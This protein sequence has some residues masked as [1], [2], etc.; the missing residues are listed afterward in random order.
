MTIKTY[1]QEF[2]ANGGQTVCIELH[3]PPRGTINKFTLQSYGVAGNFSYRVVDRGDL[4]PGAEATSESAVPADSMDPD[5]DAAAQV[6]K[7]TVEMHEVLPYVTV[8]DGL[9]QLFQVNYQY[10]N[11]DEQRNPYKDRLYLHVTNNDGNP[12]EFGVA[13]TYEAPILGG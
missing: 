2:G 12:H 10:E 13:I 8:T 5:R 1:M 6:F 4:C 11:Q 9:E 3:V 7:G